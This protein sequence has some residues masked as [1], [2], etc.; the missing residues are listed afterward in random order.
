MHLRLLV[1]SGA[2]VALAFPFAA[3][4]Q[5]EPPPPYL[6]T[7]GGQ[8]VA[9]A[10]STSSDEMGPGDTIAFIAGL[11]EN[12]AAF[13]SLQVVN[14]SEADESRSR[15]EIIFNGRV[16]CVEPMGEN[17]ARFGGEGR[18]PDGT[19]SFFTVDVTD[20]GDQDRGTD[21]VLF[22]TSSDRPCDDEE[23]TELN[24]TMLARGN[25]K[26]DTANSEGGQ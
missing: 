12:E 15:P 9:E 11:D 16:E 20:T 4:A 5:E 10:D 14:T 21:Q 8:V 24:G 18:A 17:M 22:R 13:G 6:V 26:V 2:A 19:T 7:G 23:G 25:V 3:S 1:A